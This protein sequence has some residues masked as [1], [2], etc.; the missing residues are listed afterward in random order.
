MTQLGAEDLV[1]GEEVVRRKILL[2]ERAFADFAALTGDAHPIHYDADYAQAIGLQAPIA[3]GLLITAITALG[4]TPLSDR[5]KGSMIAMLGI[6]SQ[7][8]SP[9]FV[10]STVTVVMRV[11]S[12]ERKTANR[13]IAVFGIDVLSN[14]GEVHARVT[15]RYM[16]R[17]SIEKDAI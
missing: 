11:T 9:V 17:T 16:L 15:H 10:G 8:H 1:P 6:E 13:C 12:I 3:H 7:F 14:S 4:A 5:L 2:D